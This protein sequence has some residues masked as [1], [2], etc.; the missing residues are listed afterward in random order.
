MKYILW[1]LFIIS[2]K[3]AFFVCCKKQTISVRTY[4]LKKKWTLVSQNDKTWKF[5]SMIE[6]SVCL[7][8]YCKIHFILLPLWYSSNRHKIK[9]FVEH[10]LV[11]KWSQPLL[12]LATYFLG[13]IQLW[14]CLMLLPTA[15]IKI[16]WST[17]HVRVSFVVLILF[18]IINISCNLD[19]RLVS[20]K[21]AFFRETCKK[22]PDV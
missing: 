21:S 18:V 8:I 10:N 14:I 3:T 7:E 22:I 2:K 5:V 12:N 19:T 4:L 1:T 13:G 9:P 15:T 6:P 20:Y 11:L 17:T 16:W